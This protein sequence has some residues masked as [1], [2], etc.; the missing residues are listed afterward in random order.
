MGKGSGEWS[1][2]GISRR[3][4]PGVGGEVQLLLEEQHERRCG[5]RVRA[6]LEGE[7]GRAGGRAGADWASG[8]W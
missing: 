4:G 7:A 3:K 1:W 5:W 2:C 6:S 8:P